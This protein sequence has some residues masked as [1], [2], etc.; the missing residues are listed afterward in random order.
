MLALAPSSTEI[1]R[2]APNRISLT[3]P[4][5][6]PSSC[7][8]RPGTSSSSGSRYP[9]PTRTG[10]T[11]MA[12]PTC[13]RR[14]AASPPNARPRRS[15]ADRRSPRRDWPGSRRRSP[16]TV[17]VSARRKFSGSAGSTKWQV[18]PSF[19]NDRPNWVSEPP[20]RLREAR[21]SSPGSS[22]VAKTRNCA[23]W[24]EAAATAAR[25]PSRLATRSSSTDTV[26][27]VRRE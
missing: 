10:G 12:L 11:D 15:P 22:S 9:R 21:N 24:P 27:L 1:F 4:R 19:L 6:R 14:S 13:Y 17:G 3:R 16:C 23:A 18:Q 7:R 5:S 25:P 20:Y 26:G 8:G 2:S